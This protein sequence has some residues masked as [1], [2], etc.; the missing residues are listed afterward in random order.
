MEHATSQPTLFTWTPPRKKG[1]RPNGFAR[2]LA[3]VVRYGAEMAPRPKRRKPAQAKLKECPRCHRTGEVDR[4]F[5][6]R[7]VRGEA[8]P[9]SWCRGCRSA[10]APR[11]GAPQLDLLQG[12]LAGAR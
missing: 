10:T 12:G 11:E 4:D 7:M 8:R 9:Q 2:A 5:G 6:M 3:I 1:P